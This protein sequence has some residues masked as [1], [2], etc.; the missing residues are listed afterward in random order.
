MD[1]YSDIHLEF[2]ENEEFPKYARNN[3]ILILAGDIGNTGNTSLLNFLA[4]CSKTWETV[5]YVPGN[6][7]Y[8]VRQTMEEID[9]GITE[10]IKQFPNIFYLNNKSVVINGIKYVGSTYWSKPIDWTMINDF[11]CI[12]VSKQRSGQY[13]KITTKIMGSL[14]DRDLAFLERENGDVIITHFPPMKKCL[15]ESDN[16]SYFVNNTDM[17]RFKNVKTWISGHTHQS[18]DFLDNGVR[19]VSNQIG[20]KD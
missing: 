16:L 12:Y 5:L 6:H 14:H 15:R 9:K 17:S 19:F 11:R 1:I 20:Y 3:P 10:M 2:F 18:Y 13:N 4:Y 8:Y 7:E